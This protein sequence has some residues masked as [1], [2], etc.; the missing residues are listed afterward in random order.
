MSK[1]HG[2][3]VAVSLDENDLSQYSN[4]TEWSRSADTHDTTTYG[5]NAKTY[6]GGLLDGTATIEG[7]YDNTADSG[8][9]AVIEPLL[10]QTVPFEYQPE[11]AS[12]GITRTVDVVV[13]SYDES[14]PVA[15]MITFTCELQMSDDVE[16]TDTTA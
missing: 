12:T 4:S 16:I 10:G 14:A 2:K 1:V 11:G 8:P 6:K 15:D 7:F 13:S 3:G 5:K 9:A